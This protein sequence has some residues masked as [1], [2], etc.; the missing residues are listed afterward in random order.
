[1]L[2]QLPAELITHIVRLAVTPSF[3]PPDYRVRLDTLLSLCQ[4]NKTLCGISQPILFEAVRVESTNSLGLFLS[5]VERSEPGRA[6]KSVHIVET[7][8]LSSEARELSKRCTNIVDLYVCGEEIKLSLLEG[9]KGLTTLTLA[10]TWLRDVAPPSLPA[11]SSLSILGCRQDTP[12]TD[13]SLLTPQGFPSLA[14][15]HL[16]HA[17]HSSAVFR[18]FSPDFF[19][20]LPA[21][22]V[23]LSI[24]TAFDLA[25]NDAL[26]AGATKESVLVSLDL[27]DLRMVAERFTTALTVAENLRVGFSAA[28][29]SS[30]VK[31]WPNDPLW[32][33]E[34]RLSLEASLDLLNSPPSLPHLQTLY[35]PTTLQ[36]HTLAFVPLKTA[37]ED[38]LTACVKRNVE[39]VWEE[40]VHGELGSLVSSEFSRRRREAVRPAVGGVMD[41]GKETVY[42][43]LVR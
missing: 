18:L 36:P 5:A 40:P 42:R 23:G 15:V 37:V 24:R 20:I 14:A 34:A 4:V 22:S 1:M 25:S 31:S 38:V 43:A 39:V 29:P 35:L 13:F 12:A 30:L 32:Q 9:F 21:I 26:P 17:R 16:E 33:L 2:A 7:G 8:I 11:L 3:S 6:V 19:P 27:S 10:S 41:G 28:L